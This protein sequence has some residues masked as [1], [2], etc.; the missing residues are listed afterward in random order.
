MPSTIPGSFRVPHFLCRSAGRLYILAPLPPC[1]GDRV[2]V[3]GDPLPRVQTYRGQ[4][5]LGVLYPVG[6]EWFGLRSKLGAWLLCG[7]LLLVPV[8]LASLAD[9]PAPGTPPVAEQITRAG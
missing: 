5:C 7:L 4:P 9:R 8:R 1:L 6:P 3:P 2:A